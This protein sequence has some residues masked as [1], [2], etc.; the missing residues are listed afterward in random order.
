MKL[1]WRPNTQ[2]DAIIAEYV[3]WV[4]EQ[5]ECSISE[6]NNAYHNMIETGVI[7]E[8]VVWR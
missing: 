4:R 5:A 6:H 7:R 2:L 3:D 1:G 8:A